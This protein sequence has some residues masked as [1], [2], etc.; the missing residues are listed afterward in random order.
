L[1]IA[2]VLPGFVVLWGISLH[3]AV[4]ASWLRASQDMPTVGGFLFATLGSVGL[5]LFVST[6][7]WL[8]IDP[9]HHATAVRPPD[10]DFCQLEQKLQAF[11]LLV[12]SHY[13]YYQFH[14]N[15]I[16]ALAFAYAAWRLSTAT[17]RLGPFDLIFL[18]AEAVLFIGSRDTLWKY[19]VRGDTILRCRS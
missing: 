6:L 5:G 11:Q 14:S 4:V 12:E 7:R 3:S 2:Y 17:L 8:V 1:L 18:G 15:M 16:L 10:W 13:R 9:I 19:Y